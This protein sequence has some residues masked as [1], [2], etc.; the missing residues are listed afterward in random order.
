MEPYTWL[1]YAATH[2]PN[3]WG[4]YRWCRQ[5]EM[6]EEFYYNNVCRTIACDK[7]GFKDWCHYMPWTK[8]LINK[9]C[10]FPYVVYYAFYDKIAMPIYTWY[11]RHFKKGEYLTCFSCG[12]KEDEL[13]KYTLEDMGYCRRN[14]RWFCHHCDCHQYDD[15]IDGKGKVSHEE[16]EEYWKEEVKKHNERL[17]K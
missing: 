12:W 14:G 15:W 17:N 8:K 5:R 11:W 4:Y 2:K 16:Y 3:I 6:F 1:Q 10:R 7:C 13:N 9:I